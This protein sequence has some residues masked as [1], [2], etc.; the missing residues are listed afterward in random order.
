MSKQEEVKDLQNIKDQIKK[1]DQKII[2]QV[3]NIDQKFV[4]RNKKFEENIHD[5]ITK[6]DQNLNKDIS[7]LDQKV[8]EQITK[9]QKESKEQFKQLEM[10][11]NDQFNIINKKIEDITNLY[12]Q[13]LKDK[14]STLEL[15]LEEKLNNLNNKYIELENR[16]KQLIDSIENRI[17]AIGDN[18]KAVS[19][20]LSIKIQQFKEGFETKEEVLRDMFKKFESENIEFHESLKPILENLKSQ[21]D[22]VKI[23]MDVLK[24][25]IYESAKEWISEEIKLACKNKE[26]EI[27]MN[28]WIDEMKDIINNLDKLKE[29]NP[30]DFKIH[31]NEIYATIESFKQKFM[32]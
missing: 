32:K 18:L 13:E 20:D 16:H 4:D 29:T 8:S 3:R 14:I 5:Q 12:D 30:K 25:Q 11:L 24:K 21:Q 17:R 19:D 26:K 23:S 7:T 15:K 31:I 28:L 6:L 1:I 10:K 22:L 9:V 2:D 27:L